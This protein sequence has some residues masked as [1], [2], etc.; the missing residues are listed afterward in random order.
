MTNWQALQ[1]ADYQIKQ[2]LTCRLYEPR[3]QE[4]ESL[5]AHHMYQRLVSPGE[6]SLFCLKIALDPMANVRVVQVG[7][8]RY[9]K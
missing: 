2:L 7:S 6:S 5:R 9:Q 3:G 4:F 1:V 8:C